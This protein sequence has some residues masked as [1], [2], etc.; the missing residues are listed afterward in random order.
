[1]NLLK[2]RKT[3]SPFEKTFLG[4][5]D[6]SKNL[7]KMFVIKALAKRVGLVLVFTLVFALG[8]AWGQK[9]SRQ[10]GTL[11]TAATW[12][13]IVAGTGN[14]TTTVGST[15]GTNATA[16]SIAINDA[17]FDNANNFIGIV[18]AT[19]T[20]TTFTLQNTALVS[21]TGAAFKKQGAVA[22]TVAP[23]INDY[24]VIRATHTITINPAFSTN[25][26]IVNNGSF[27]LTAGLT[28]NAGATYIHYQNGGAIPAATW[29]ATSNCNVIGIVGTALTAIGVGTTFGNFT[30]SCAGQTVANTLLNAAGTLTIGG[31]LNITN[32]NTQTLRLCAS[33]NIITL[34]VNGDFAVG[35]GVT[36]TT[37]NLQTNNRLVTVE[38]GGNVIVNNLAT[39]TQTGTTTGTFNFGYTGATTTTSVTWGGAGTYINTN[40]NYVVQ[41]VPAGKTVTL[42]KATMDIPAGRSL[43]INNGA[44]YDV[45]SN[46]VNGGGTFTLS[47]GATLITANTVGI[48]AAI[49]TLTGSIQTTTARSFSTTANYTYNGTGDQLTGTGLPA[50][51][52]NFA[53]AGGGGVKTLSS[54]IAVSGTLN[55]GSGTTLDPAANNLTVTGLSTIVGTLGDSNAGGSTS[56][57]GVD[58]SGG[59]INHGT[60]DDVTIGTT[61]TMP[62]GNGT[63]GNV[64]LTVTGGTTI[65]NGSTLNINNTGGTKTFNGAVINNG[66]WNCS[67]N[68]D[69][70]FGGGLNNSG[71]S[72]TSGSGVYSFN[73][74]QNISGTSAITF[75]GNVMVSAAL[76]TVSNTNSNSITINGVLNGS[77]GSSTWTQTNGSTLNI[78]NAAAPMI[79]GTL[80]AST[81]ANT[82]NYNFGG[83]QDIEAAT[84]YNLTLSNSGT[85]TTNG[86][87]TVNGAFTS[88]IGIPLATAND[89]TYNGTTACGGGTI[90]ASAGTV[91]YANSATSILAGTYNNLTISGAAIKTLCGNITV[92]GVL[93]LGGQLNTNGYD[94]SLNGTPACGTGSINALTGTFTY[95][96]STSNIIAGTYNNLTI[97]NGVAATVCAGTTNVNGTL[98]LNGTTLNIN[99]STLSAETVTRNNTNTINISTGTFTVNNNLLLP[100][101][102]NIT[103]SG[104]GTLHVLGSLTCG[105]LTG[106]AGTIIIGDSFTPNSFVS[107]TSTVNFDGA[108]P[109]TIPALNY[110]NLICSSTG[111]RTLANTGTIGIAGTFTPAGN[112]YTLTGSTVNFNNT[113]AQF[114]AA[115]TYNNLSVSGSGTKTLSGALSVNNNLDISGTATLASD[116]YQ[117]AG[118]ATGALTM[119]A[120][121]GLTL[122]N[123]G[124]ATDVLFPTL[125]TTITLNNTSTVTY[126]NNSAQTVAGVTYGNLII[127][128][129]NVKSLGGNTTV[130][131]LL[132]LTNG[133]ISLGGFNLTVNNAISGSFD[134]THM[135]VTGGTGAL[136]KQGTIANASMVYP[137]GTSSKYT[138]VTIA[139][140]AGAATGG[141]SVRAIS[142]TSSNMAAGSAALSKYWEILTPDY[143]LNSGSITL[144]WH[145]TEALGDP[146]SFSL[147]Q[148]IVGPAWEK[149]TAT[150]GTNSLTHTLANTV[151]GEW[152]AMERA[153]LYSYKTGNW[154]TADTWT[155]DPSGTE[156]I[157]SRVPLD[158]DRVIIL[159]GYTVTLNQN[160]TTLSNSLS[161]E[162]G[163]ILNLSDYRFDN[164]LMNLEGAGTIKSAYVGGAPSTGYFP[165]ATSNTFVSSDGGTYEYIYA[166][167]LTE[168]NLPA[169]ATYNHLKINIPA[170]KKAIQISNLTLNGNLLVQQGIFQINDATA[171]TLNLI[172]YGNVSVETSGQIITGTGSTG[173]VIVSPYHS[174]AHQFYIYG[175]LTNNGTIKFSN[176][177]NPVYNAFPADGAVTVRFTGATNN[178]A[179]LSGTTNFYNLIIDKGT[180]K[181][182][183]LEIASSNVA[184][185]R[186]FGK[187]NNFNSELVIN[188]FSLDN[189]EV[190]KALWIKNGT[191]K[192][193]GKINIPTLSEGAVAGTGDSNGDWR[194]G[195]NA[196]L[197]IASP[198][199]SVSTTSTNVADG[200]GVD[201]GRGYSAVSIFGTL[202]VTDGSFTTNNGMGVV[203]WN[204]ATNTA[205]LTIEGGTVDASCFWTTGGVG[206][207]S[208]YQSGGTFTVRGSGGAYPVSDVSANDPLFGI[209]NP[210]CSFTMTGGTITLVNN[211]NA[212]VANGGNGFCVLS[213]AGNFAVTGGKIN[214]V[215]NSA[216]K[217]TFDI[218]STSNLW[219][220]DLT[221]TDIN[222]VTINLLQ[223]LT[224]SNDL[225]IGDATTLDVSATNYNLS[226]GGDFTLGQT[227]GATNGAVYNYRAN[228]TTFINSGTSII[229]VLR[230]DNTTSPLIFNNL[231][232]NKTNASDIVQFISA[233]RSTL[234][235]DAG[236]IVGTVNSTLTNS[237]GTLDYGAFR[238]SALGNVVNNSTLGPNASTGRLYL[239]STALQTISASS[240]GSPS[241]GHLDI[242]GTNATTAAQLSSDVVV[243]QLTLT[244]DRIFDIG[245][246][247]LTVNTNPINGTFSATRMIRTAGN[248]SDKGL[249]MGISGNYPVSTSIATFPV[250]TAYG[251]TPAEVR[252]NAT[253]A[254]G[255]LSGTYTIIPVNSAHPAASLGAYVINYYWKSKSSITGATNANIDIRYTF[256]TVP[257]SFNFF[258]FF[259]AYY[260][261]WLINT[262]ATDMGNDV[263]SQSLIPFIATGFINSDYSVGATAFGISPFSLLVRTLYSRNAGNPGNWTNNNTWCT[264][265]DGTGAAVAPPAAQDKVFIRDGHT[266]TVD[267]NTQTCA[268]LS[269]GVGSILNLGTTTGHSFDVVTGTGKMSISATTSPA[270][271][272]SGDFGDFLG[273]GGG[274]VEYYTTG[275]VNFVIPTRQG[276]TENLTP[277]T[278]Y[279]YLQLTPASGQYIAMPNSDLIIYNNLVVAGASATGIARINT[280]A[281]R[282]LAISGD[283]LVN[284]GDLQFR[285]RNIANTANGTSQILN[286]AGNTTVANGALFNMD[287]TAA[288]SNTLNITG[289]LTNNGTIDFNNTNSCSLI[290]NG[291][292]NQSLT[293]TGTG[294]TD[295]YNLTINKGII[296]TPTLTIDV[297]GTLTT[298][299]NNWLT[300]SNGTLKYMKGNTLNVSTNTSFSIPKTACLHVENASANIVIANAAVDNNDLMLDGK[301]K[302]VNGAVNIGSAANNSNNDIEYSTSGS[303][304]IEISGGTL[305]VNG[306]I[307]RSLINIDCVLKYSQ[308]LGDVTINGRNS[309]NT[310]A[311]FEV[312]NTGSVFTLTGGSLTI[313][314]GGG[315]TTFS[316]LYVRPA[317]YSTSSAGNIYLST[318]AAC[319]ATET[320]RV[321]A[322]VPLSGLSVNGFDATHTALVYLNINPITLNGPLNINQ[323]ATF[324]TN[325]LNLTLSGNFT[326]SGIFTS[327]TSDITTFSGVSQNLTGNN[328]TFCNLAI[329]PTTSVTL[330]PASNITVNKELRILSGSLIDGGNIITVKKN[331]VNYTTHTS[332][333]PAAGGIRLQGSLNQIISG[334]GTATPAYF[335]RLELDNT[336]GA[337]LQQDITI[338][339][340]LTLTNGSINID[341]QLLTI[342]T[343]ATVTS[344]SGTFGTS[345]MIYTNG[346]LTTAKGVT[347]P[348]KTTASL[349][350]FLCPIG[351]N[352]K[353]TPVRIAFT[354]NSTAGTVNFSPINGPHPTA[355][356]PD[357]VL[358]YYWIISS[359]GISNFK[360]DIF[361]RYL[362]ADVRVKLPDDETDYISGR[363]T[364]VTWTKLPA[365]VDATNDTVQFP[366][367]S[368][369]SDISGEYTAGIDAA[370]PITVPTYYSN[371]PAGG[372]WGD[373]NT[374]L[375]IP[376]SGVPSGAIMVIQ[377]GH[378]V[379]LETDR[380]Q[381][382]KTTINGNLAVGNTIGHYLGIVDGTGILSVTDQKLPAG[383]YD[384]FFSCTGGSLEYG[385]GGTP[386][387]YTM[388]LIPSTMRK[389]FLSGGGKRIM[390][391]KDITICE[392]I[393]IGGTSTLDNTV[394][395]RA[396]YLNGSMT[397]NGT[398]YFLSGTGSTA[399]VLFQGNSAQSIG[400]F[401]TTNAF[402]NITINNSNSA[403]VT[404]NG[405][406]DM[407]GDLTLT[408]GILTTTGQI[409]YMNS[410]TSSVSPSGGSS[411]SFI[412]GPLKKKITGGYLFQFPIGKGTRYGKASINLANDGDWTAEYFDS[413]RSGTASP[414]F[415]APL[416]AASTTE[417]WT[418]SGPASKQAYVTLR[419]DPLSDIR[420]AVSSSGISG[421][422]VGEYNTTSNQW[423]EKNTS[424][425]GDNNNGNSSTT[426]KMNLDTHDYT[427]AC[428]GTINARARFSSTANVCV[429]GTIP[430]E[431]TGITGQYTYTLFYTDGTNALSKTGINASTTTIPATIAGV[432]SITGFTYNNP[433]TPT[434]GIFDAT[435]V[436]VNAAP[437]APANWAG[438]DQ[439]GATMCGRTSTTLAGL[440]PTVGTGLWSIFAGTG[441][442][443]ANPTSRTSAFSGTAGQTYT[444]QWIISNSPCASIT[445]NVII[446]FY[447]APAITLAGNTPVCAGSSN[448]YTTEAAMTSYAWSV[449]NGVIS[450]GGSGTDRT[451]TVTW[452]SAS[453]GQVSVNYTDGNGCT[454]AL[455]TDLTVTLNPLP[456]ATLSVNPA[457][458][459]I[460]D[461]ENTEILLTVTTGATPFDFTISDGVRVPTETFI[462]RVSP[463]TYIPASRP[464]WSLP[465]AGKVY[466]YS[467]TNITDNN[468]CSNTGANTVEVT[469]F[470]IPE[471]GP[472]YHVPNNF[473][474]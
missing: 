171:Q 314:R 242:A 244:S 413:G 11:A 61:L 14:I 170:V 109:Q 207:G 307:R 87:I 381:S 145:T 178:Q 176:Q 78:N 55:I 245:V 116:I 160:V 224:V 409:L 85:K 299:N 345:K 10:T 346:H 71:T 466:T 6:R 209:K 355:L 9:V 180:D 368:V 191:L 200:T 104:A 229:N 465:L 175:N 158:D 70:T 174:N 252:T 338:N 152:T 329:N 230:N 374:W 79:T 462:N 44:T 15:A 12:F 97:A 226:I 115:F 219:N 389:L 162:S 294:G 121:T 364:N 407:K 396:I 286:I 420:P 52:N 362:N 206:K 292:T 181:T 165:T 163:A 352:G 150:S 335:G 379:T 237:V 187:N 433:T 309:N 80:N 272:P 353:Y 45:G 458:D 193:T 125:F 424:S 21:V 257:A 24:I 293:G 20:T 348:V 101:S 372:N 425:S 336:A 169:Q 236:S 447:Q 154:H 31:N 444:L 325:N 149:R 395:N 322:S 139:G 213:S 471:T 190:R 43:T 271:F 320:F 238:L 270:R 146:S 168:F 2:V 147:V 423:N 107:N 137:V 48:T 220:L 274:T 210:N 67:V 136:I 359:S 452:G 49:A 408:N 177:L 298:P 414:A 153:T 50:T 225:L 460:C 140:T 144:T 98:A 69:I 349:T 88:G 164:T 351:A 29:A 142:G 132:T 323:Y 339:N 417:Y 426:D 313:V 141:I 415:L 161:V 155:T 66:T 268:T 59:T 235:A 205:E 350:G 231:T 223:N 124:D 258:I 102:D 202:Q 77:A 448:V 112:T 197:W 282:T 111:A 1:M 203:F 406:V 103:F 356:D 196:R 184:N 278:N 28:F 105:T 267:A 467:I 431:F 5:F 234:I 99:G 130:N 39:L 443:I 41:N 380:K 361:M 470:K 64:N 46:V 311:K 215:L 248:S 156:L 114:I 468:G 62:T 331:I 18:S 387:D 446:A 201:M 365:L 388:S 332:S 304:E 432:Y 441:G 173:I 217:T 473:G 399:K 418:I 367:T 442:V 47:G 422:R 300:L 375:P 391:N 253:G 354:Q 38:V 428:I 22:A 430:V 371:V 3:V 264:T 19:P 287:G 119:G 269:I 397:R 404:L 247:G 34:R 290:F 216:L 110:F 57:Q 275:A 306:Q 53:T 421:M 172:V 251:Y 157:G 94:I 81:N 412:N 186:L 133:S 277:I 390:P 166:G 188:G 84:Y 296:Q 360:G 13:D 326:N 438:P 385:D 118:N 93:T 92:N 30:W 40:I 37:F 382:Y 76:V 273:S 241:I 317:T 212:T 58:L 288:I 256:N 26:T 198:D 123:T 63:I 474:L 32:T 263:S 91:T 301:L 384:S 151:S 464:I 65:A 437:S 100:T 214:V 195:A 319:A 51:V 106:N 56:L 260:H 439:T 429:G 436:T 276:P 454:A 416:S 265:A 279:R 7:S 246:Y 334:N 289:S 340:V 403:G 450:S 392:L 401:T 159:N 291:A 89:V 393:D 126:Q 321:D 303:S 451:A 402:N 75:D 369:T 138:P 305:F 143:L 337:L 127:N 295:L 239:N 469:V 411:S 357:N 315:G 113:G 194:I 358:Q 60:L 427:L 310:R 192:L 434:A 302:I 218:N 341:D 54:P 72:F 4:G 327:G 82:V 36:A 440:A 343:N 262:G 73:A 383:R 222:P 42:T 373:I 135:V 227:T 472:Q 8:Q 261:P 453:S 312:V 33:N 405:D 328:T 386:K 366:F 419:W 83:A 199:V 297:A 377:P 344:G 333:N 179:I 280:E 457:L 117:I 266:T 370:L 183:Q 249:T 129:G 122:G 347:M 221:R 16:S 284:S 189:P 185:F 68:E 182:Y 17:I 455:P 400:T 398:A 167:V 131:T 240:L 74:T 243:N 342:G 25:S 90:N 363:L 108:I 461:G 134:G 228:T 96:N 283:L 318:T 459:S 208:Y 410:G 86:A 95:S 120:G 376:A 233:G 378:T 35:N 128:G 232:I 148:W 259:T 255:S 449:T 456:V 211:S 204:N 285:S 324:N 27:T 308:T 250:G 23:G 445:D 254:S 463:F 316:D 435:T 281:A 330:Q 394:N